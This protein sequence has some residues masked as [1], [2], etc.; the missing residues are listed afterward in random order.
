MT[1]F[2]GRIRDSFKRVYKLVD[3]QHTEALLDERH[4][5][6]TELNQISRDVE[7]QVKEADDYISELEE[8]L[9]SRMP[10][11]NFPSRSPDFT[12]DLQSSKAKVRSK[13][14]DV[15]VRTIKVPF[16]GKL[17]FPPYTGIM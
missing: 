15:P 1:A 8:K 10:T 5:I 2:C 3:D 16:G 9:M 17:M 13:T 6:H 7:I 4:N 12:S 14:K 11:E